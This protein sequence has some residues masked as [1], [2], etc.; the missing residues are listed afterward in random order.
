MSYLRSTCVVS[1][2]LGLCG[3]VAA[4]VSF[5]GC[6]DRTGVLLQVTRDEAT[7]PEDIEKLRFFVGVEV[8]PGEGLAGDFMD[9]VDPSEEVVLESPRDLLSDPYRLLLNRGGTEADKLMIAVA[10][11]KGG[12]I[13]GFGGL[14]SAVAFLDGK[15]LQWEIVLKGGQPGRIEITSTGCLVWATEGGTVVIVSPTDLDCDDDP[16]DSDCNDL[17]PTVGH[18][19]PE[20]CYN[21]VDDDCDDLTDEQEDADDD[22]VGNCEDCDDTNEFRFPG[23]PEVC[24]GM[25][26]DCNEVCDDGPLDYD[27]DDYTVC[28]RKILPDGTC[29]D[30]NENLFDCDDDDEFTHP[31]ASE[32][33]DG[34]D[35]NCNGHCDEGHDPDGD[36][37]TICG[38]HTDICN[39]IKADHIDCEPNDEHAFPGNLPEICDGVDN[40]CDGL[41][42]P[43]SVPCYAVTDEGGEPECMVGWR[44]CGDDID[45]SWLSDCS[46]AADPAEKVPMEFCEAYDDCGDAADPWEC[47]NS[48]VLPTGATCQLAYLQDA[49]HELCLPAWYFLDNTATVLQCYWA[50]V[51]ASSLPPNYVVGFTDDGTTGPVNADI[52]QC[53]P[54]F[55]VH[56]SLTVPPLPDSYLIYQEESYDWSRVFRLDIVPVPVETC[57]PEN[58]LQCT[59]LPPP[60]D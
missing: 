36:Q 49:P 43:E 15:V 45:E 48:E 25:D 47:A 22:G 51:P 52:A 26:N 34:K 11:Y 23:N 33:C 10:G 53:R 44:T 19:M 50:I 7:T 30:V 1:R 57:P 18:G 9:D 38:S 59:N 42:Y 12:E 60:G 55:V 41:Y 3:L 40:N 32:M 27:M 8:E 2:G 21:D 17:D 31:G 58:G 56:S 4:L 14:D 39:G 5:H 6:A 35:N 37:Y 16:S 28:D 29:T 54:H 20:L 46:P 13:V 24:D